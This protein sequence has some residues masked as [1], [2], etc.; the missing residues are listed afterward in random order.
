MSR[1]PPHVQLRLDLDRGDE[2][3]QTFEEWFLALPKTPTSGHTIPQPQ[4]N[5][6][7][8]DLAVELR[9]GDALLLLRD[10]EDEVGRATKVGGS[11]GEVAAD[12]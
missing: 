1:A 12:V 3:E 8:N 11:C 2:D 10:I 6:R 9:Y 4:A 5:N 7:S